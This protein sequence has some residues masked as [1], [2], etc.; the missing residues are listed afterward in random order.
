[1][2]IGTHHTRHRRGALALARDD[3]RRGALALARDDR[4]GKKNDGW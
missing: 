3:H 1:V 4:G 2:R